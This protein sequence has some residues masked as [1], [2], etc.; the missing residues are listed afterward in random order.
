MHRQR[1]RRKQIPQAFIGSY[2]SLM[3]QITRDDKAI[4]IALMRHS[5]SDASGQPF[6]WVWRIRSGV[7]VDMD[8]REDEKFR[9]WFHR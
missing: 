8:V 9:G 6:V 5:M 4:S 3:S 2:I 7:Y 1:E